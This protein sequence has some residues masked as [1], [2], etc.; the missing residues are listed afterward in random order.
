[1]THNTFRACRSVA[2]GFP[3]GFL[4]SALVVFLFL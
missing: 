1:M 2:I 4:F 3:A